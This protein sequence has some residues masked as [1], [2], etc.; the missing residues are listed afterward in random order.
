MAEILPKKISIDCTGHSPCID[1]ENPGIDLAYDERGAG[2]TLILIHGLDGG[3]WSWRRQIAELSKA[4]RVIAMDLPGHGQSGHRA[5]GTINIRAFADAVIAL[6]QALGVEQGHFCGH[7]LGGMII[8]E[9][10]VR[11]RS[12]MQSLI[13]ADTTAFFPPPQIL[14]DFLGCFDHLDMPS[15]A[16][17]MA[18]R[19][20]RRGAPAALIEEVEEDISA[21]SRAVYRQ[22]LIAA[23]QADY[24]WILPAIDLPTSILVGEMDQATPWGYARYLES[25][26][27]NSSLWVVPNAA[28]LAH[29]ENPQ[30]FNRLLGLHLKGVRDSK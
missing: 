23:F 25:Q 20:L 22:A 7:C 17:F 26:I 27:K 9:I 2:E 4:Y 30:E 11:Y 21:A 3:G 15:W 18:P 6:L 16:R 10:F 8:L 13:L 29:R 19:L 1:L 12:L 14:G 28:H 24:R 5:D